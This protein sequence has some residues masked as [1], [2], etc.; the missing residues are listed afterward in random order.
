M[1]KDFKLSKTDAL[2][3]VDAQKDFCPNGAL[4]IPEGDQVIPALNDYIKNF[5]KSNAKIF[6]T[7]D[8]HPPDHMSFKAQGGPWPP[9][10]IQDS[11]GAKFHPQLKL[12]NDTTIIS[13]ATDPLKE[14]YSGF[15]KTELER[16]LTSQGITRLFVSGLATDYCV[17]NT[18]LDARKLGFETIL[19]LDATRG[20]NLEPGDVAKAI[21]EMIKSG[22]EQA[23]LTDF[24]DP[25]EVPLTEDADT[26]NFGAKSL[27]KVETKKKARMRPKG[28]YKR[29]RTERG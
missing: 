8:W 2:I 28:P 7:R 27:A 10:G 22:A 11:D 4:P 16:T 5:K 13:K 24:S 26:E 15:D 14:A 6:A 9:H 19:L 3:I 21:D 17:K 20:I 1:N 12:P 29:V 23:T 25:L 18:V